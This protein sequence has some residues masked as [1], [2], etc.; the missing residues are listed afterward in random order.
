M[1]LGLSSDQT[2]MYVVADFHQWKEEWRLHPAQIGESADCQV[3][4]AV[5]YQKLYFAAQ[6]EKVVVAAA[7]AVLRL[8]AAP[9]Q[10][11]H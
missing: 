4:V 1:E 3:V 11:L 10:C 9:E 6:S 5:D 2:G 8:A 7:A